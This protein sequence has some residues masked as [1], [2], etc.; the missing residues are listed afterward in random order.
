MA[1]ADTETPSIKTPGLPMVL[2]APR[3]RPSLARNQT[4][5][6]FVSHLL[7]ARSQD[8]ESAAAVGGALA[9]YSQG[10]KMS[11]RRLPQGYRKTVI[12]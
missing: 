1:D 2:E 7:A 11:A 4:T 12:A 5:A 9:T 10:A 6:T 8:D 3:P